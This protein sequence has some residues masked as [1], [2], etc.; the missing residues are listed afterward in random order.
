MGARRLGRRFKRR[1][2]GILSMNRL[3]L[4]A[5]SALALSMPVV[6]LTACQGG[7]D[8]SS[9]AARQKEA[10]ARVVAVASPLPSEAV[11]VVGDREVAKRDYET[12]LEQTRA[13]Y[14]SQGRK[15]PNPGTPE[16][17]VLKYNLVQFLV[18]RAQLEQKAKELGIVVTDEQVEDRLATIKKTRFGGS[19]AKFDKLLAQRH[20]TLASVEGDIRAQ[21]VQ[22]RLYAKVTRGVTV[23]DREVR[24][25]YNDHPNLY[26]TSRATSFDR[27][28]RAIRQQL[29]AAKKSDTM[30]DWVEATARELGRQTSYQTGFLPPAERSRTRRTSP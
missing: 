9:P 13:R 5:G 10:G 29:L 11:A 26:G 23:S 1:A 22:E 2:E 8:D 7:S 17:T 20:L 21:I 12:F 4:L 27:V 18:R 25:Y 24:A 14:R 3:R 30:T 16:W 15:L 19:E 6:L 28:K